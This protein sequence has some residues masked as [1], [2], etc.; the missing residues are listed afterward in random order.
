MPGVLGAA[1]DRRCVSNKEDRVMAVDLFGEGVRAVSDQARIV[2]R[3]HIR[4]K[5]F[6]RG[7]ICCLDYFPPNVGFREISSK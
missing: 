7:I 4:Q 1:E 6:L 2:Y 5:T 3:R